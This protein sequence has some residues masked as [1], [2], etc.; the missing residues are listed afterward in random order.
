VAVVPPSLT[1]REQAITW[2]LRCGFSARKHTGWLGEA[3]SVSRPVHQLHASAS[4]EDALLVYPEADGWMVAHSL[5][6]RR[7]VAQ[8]FASLTEAVEHVLITLGGNPR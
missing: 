3:I 1:S 8:H 2:L 6:G 5:P 7:G 4:Y